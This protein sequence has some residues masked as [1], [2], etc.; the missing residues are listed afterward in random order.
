[1][2]VWET[3]ITLDADS[4]AVRDIRIG[5]DRQTFLKEYPDDELVAELKRRDYGDWCDEATGSEIVHTVLSR[6][7]ESEVL[8]KV[9]NSV[10]EEEMESRS[11]AIAD[12]SAHGIAEKM[13]VDNN[14]RGI[15]DN[16]DIIKL[17][18]AVTGKFVFRKKT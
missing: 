1:M 2:M 14:H 13:L 4:D 16:G 6:G 12:I 11:L 5:I 7:M 17:I 8:R 18:E 9:D 10:L 15:I 3:Y